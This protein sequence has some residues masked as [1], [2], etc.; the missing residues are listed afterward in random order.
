MAKSTSHRALDAA[1]EYIAGRADTLALCAGA[2]ASAEEALTPVDAGGRMLALAA[3]VPGLGNGDFELAP[4]AASGRRLVVGGRDG[5]AVVAS[6]LADHLVLVAGALGEILIVTA[7]AE[8]CELVEGGTV[9]ARGFSHE[10][11]D[12]A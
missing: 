11:A 6:G 7:L 2:P 5:V 1:S 10:I 9:A 3:V 4:G 8:A 12:P